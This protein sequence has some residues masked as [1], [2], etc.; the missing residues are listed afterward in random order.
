MKIAA[1]LCAG[2]L[3]SCFNSCIAS[4]SF[5]DELKLADIVPVHKKDDT[6][7]K[8]NY[9][10]ISLLPT[11]SKVFE[12][13]IKKQIEPFINTWL[14]KF[15][16]GFRK[17]YNPQYAILN[18]LRDWQ[19]SLNTSGRVGAVLMDLSKA[20]DCLPHDL[21]IAKMAAYGFGH[22]ALRLF[23]SYLT[24]RKHRV[25][26]G[27]SISEYLNLLLGVPQGSVLGPIL[28]NIFINDLLLTIQE[29]SI[30]NFADDNTIY[31]CDLS[32]PRI[33]NRLES[34]LA[35]VSSWFSNNGMVA[36]PDKF[37]L[38]FPGTVNDIVIKVGGLH[39]I[40]SNEVKLLGVKI[41]NQLTFHAHISDI[42]KQAITKT[43]AL[44]RIRNYLNQNQADLIFNA[45]IMPAFQYCPLIW[46][47]CSKMAHNLINKTH[48]RVLRAR[49]N[50]FSE[51]FSEM[52]QIANTVSIHTRN[53]RLLMTEI[54]KSLKELNPPIMWNTFQ[55]KTCH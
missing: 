55:V 24:N 38:I 29:S 36:N 49:F 10:P 16:C 51:S 31:V 34:D 15:L 4:Q 14:S 33:I 27:S 45:F 52:L 11:V 21:I 17:G 6:T 18:M 46:M 1:S 19:K 2:P 30:C 3:T 54:F 42:C 28:F 26:I 47:Y 9:R 32:I 44:M 43:K 13:L 8:L 50:T 35:L 40:S 22:Q 5:P 37:Q 53:L 20:F 48:H 7:S 12:R 23:P 41:D 25:R 39:I